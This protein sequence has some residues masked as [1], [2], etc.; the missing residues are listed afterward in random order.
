M[1]R[2]NR[3]SDNL[4]PF[5]TGAYIRN[6]RYVYVNTSNRYKPAE[7]TRNSAR[8]YT[9]HDSV[10]IGV[11]QNPKDKTLRM[12]YGNDT[13]KS[14]YLKSEL[15]EPPEF[16]D[17][18][19][20]GL[21]T[22]IAEAADQS[23]LIED[24]TNVFGTEDTQQILDLCS[25]M[26]S[27]ES[28][29]LQHYPAW[30]RDHMLFSEEIRSDT[31]LGRFLRKDITIPKIGFFRDKWA[32]RNIG[33]GR[34]FLCY[35]STNVNSQARGVAIVEHGHAKDD[36][37]L[38]QVNT[39]YVIRQDD[40]LPLTYL[41]SPGSV[42]DIAQAQ[43]MISFMNRMQELSGKKIRLVMICDRGYIS[44]KNLKQMD[45]AGI[46]YILMMRTNFNLHE[47]LADSVIDSMKSYK[48]ELISG[49]EDEELY[50]VTKTCRLYK[51]GP[52]CTAAVIWSSNIYKAN[53]KEVMS[54]IDRERKEVRSFF[55]KNKGK[56]IDPKELEWIP[57]Y[58]RLETKSGKSVREFPDNY[59]SMIGTK[60][61]IKETVK[62][63]G[64]ED[65]EEKI[66]REIQKSGIKILIG[67]DEMSAQEFVDAYSKR[68]CVE[69][70]FQALK[71]HLGMEKIGVSTEEAMH[72]KGLIWFTASI[73]HAL[74]FNSTTS[75]RSK[76]RKHNT[77]PAMIDQLE[78]IKADRD[79]RTN[80]YRRRYKTT[81][82]QNDILSKWKITEAD[83]DK[84][85]D[86]LND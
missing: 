48:N 56:D 75:L 59:G 51:N 76:D 22:W 8:G 9:D 65:D 24:L 80:E 17:S 71:S 63:I 67:R 3:S 14:M 74:L 61:I 31:T 85:I 68:D 27:R 11:L 78:A 46:G 57:G 32:V 20:V 69:K 19:S 25:Y 83:I 43:E 60:P 66:N 45:K 1:G 30:A 16:S 39:D 62:L 50:G 38:P 15:P 58:F 79:L 34:I 41:H 84:R 44:E 73:L 33:D 29:V 7:K 81:K 13:Y 28:A 49:D 55:L 86:I 77:V 53:R 18:L 26:L 52:S 6:G 72:G 10:C 40:G 21:N 35:D 37:D 42:N 82:R 2:I 70:V 4:F 54:Q 5:P 64:F 36:K 12:M 23:G 47:E